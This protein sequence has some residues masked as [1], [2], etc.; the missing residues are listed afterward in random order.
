MSPL[1]NIL[2]CFLFFATS[3]NAE[4]H[5]SAEPE[6]E[7]RLTGSSAACEDVA[8]IRNA[9]RTV[10]GRE[11]DPSGM[12]TYLE[13]MSGSDKSEAWLRKTL[14]RSPEGQRLKAARRAGRAVFGMLSAV[15][16]VLFVLLAAIGRTV[17]R[18]LAGVAGEPLPAS[19]VFRYFWLGFATVIAGLQ[20]WSL[21]LPVHSLALMGV[22]LFGGASLWS[23]ARS[24]TK[25]T[26][27]RCDMGTSAARMMHSGKWSGVV[28]WVAASIKMH[29]PVFILCAVGVIVVM[30]AVSGSAMPRIR[31]YDTFLYH[32]SAVRWTNSFPAV[33]GLANLHI[34][35]G[36]NSAWLL[37]ASLLDHGLMERRTAW[38]VPGFPVAVVTWQ[39]L[40]AL[41]LPKTGMTVRLFALL[42]LPYAF[43]QLLRTTPG[44]YF[45]SP[46]LLLQIVFFLELFRWIERRRTATPRVEHGVSLHSLFVVTPAILSFV[47]K[48]VA[49]LS[50]ALAISLMAYAMLYDVFRAGGGL[51]KWAP[52]VLPG[53]LLAGWLARNV[54]LSGWLLF[55][56]PYGQ[57]PVDWAVPAEPRGASHAES[58]QSLQGQQ[59]VIRGW[60]RQPGSGYEDAVNAPLRQWVP[61]WYERNQQAIELR[62]VLPAGLAVMTVF[63][64]VFLTCGHRKRPVFLI[65]L[66]A[67]LLAQLAFW[68]FMAPDL[69][70]G[71]VFF[72][73]LLAV[74]GCGLF[75]MAPDRRW[76]P[77]VIGVLGVA[78]L[79]TATPWVEALR[80]GVPDAAQLRIG[81]SIANPT[82]AVQ[83]DNGQIP[84]LIVY[85]PVTGDQSG[86]AM[87][88]NTPYPREQLM[89]RRP[90]SL[91]SGFRVRPLR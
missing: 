50:L 49:P 63:Y 59:D 62:R 38:I 67:L 43:K 74:S 28:R 79:A 32:W 85:V 60:A 77:F 54:V 4:I 33:P 44:L 88:P 71:D 29:W 34:R 35:L 13:I 76:R 46:A 39:L 8:M 20:L 51:R 81:R 80:A 7:D 37:F 1:K 61:A 16:L 30:L 78:F 45:D 56:A 9:Y 41:F 72:W 25:A 14:R 84:P 2:Y 42:C 90:G 89:A 57:L 18:Q 10:L 70:F 19:D 21:L 64:G 17:F 15:W 75:A 86:D 36:T 68:F 69:R 65:A 55:P 5:G 22:V 53:I 11:P 83:L 47:I 26:P 66:P 24:R 40:H 23:A 48:P 52:G 82:R 31:A 6:G 12:R 87:L 58:I 3:A 73:L 27:G 91:R